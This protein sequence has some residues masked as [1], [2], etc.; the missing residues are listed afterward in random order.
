MK[1][2][3]EACRTQVSAASSVVQLS[4]LAVEGKYG[5]LYLCQ[6]KG[7]TL[8]ND[9]HYS[10]VAMIPLGVRQWGVGGVTSP[11][12]VARINGCSR[13]YL[14]HANYVAGVHSVPS[15]DSR[16][17][18]FERFQLSGVLGVPRGSTGQ[19]AGCRTPPVLCVKDPCD[20]FPVSEV[21]API[22]MGDPQNEA[23]VATVSD[24]P[25]MK[26]DTFIGHSPCWHRHSFLY[27]P[28][29]FPTTTITVSSSTS[30]FV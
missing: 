10:A 5:H 13:V 16:R 18:S 4:L 21:C 27:W 2:D 29:Y 28:E 23:F 22:I 3:T 14:P 19:P 8:P 7:S 25:C 1:S 12:V 20:D 24:Q 17:S 30:M 11:F 9:V 15:F 6:S 26:V